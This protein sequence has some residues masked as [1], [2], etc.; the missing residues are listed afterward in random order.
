M[1][2]QVNFS[3]LKQHVFKENLLGHYGFL[4]RMRQ[5]REDE[6]LA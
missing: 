1:A 4:D 5:V 2:T 6:Q 3:E